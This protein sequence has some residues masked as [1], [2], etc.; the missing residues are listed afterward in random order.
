MDLTDEAIEEFQIAVKLVSP[1]D[2]AQR[3]LHC[4]SLLGHCFM[5][6]GLP[7]VALNWFQKGLEPKNLPE[8]VILALRYEMGL[9]Y[10][11]MGDIDKALETFM[12]VYGINVSYRG[13][14]DKLR[15]LQTLQP[16]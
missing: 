12:E 3:H 5:Q 15:E 2:E 1:D 13:V 16:A 6:K 8:E 10:E 9:A 14:G 11:Q 4:C 7:R